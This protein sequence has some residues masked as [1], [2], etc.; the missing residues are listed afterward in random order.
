MFRSKDLPNIEENNI[1]FSKNQKMCIALAR[2]LYSYANTFLLNN[3]LFAL[4]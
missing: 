4:D 1:K 3:F 2:A